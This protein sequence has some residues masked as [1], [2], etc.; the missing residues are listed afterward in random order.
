M[1][2]QAEGPPSAP[3]TKRQNL[4]KGRT[5][6]NNLHQTIYTKHAHEAH[7]KKDGPRPHQEGGT[8]WG[9][10]LVLF[11]VSVTK[12]QVQ[13]E[14]KVTPNITGPTWAMENPAHKAGPTTHR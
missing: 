11:C 6:R 8:E 3:S 2:T 5:Y 1:P 14:T 9:C 12:T 7:K 10:G 13:S 4:R